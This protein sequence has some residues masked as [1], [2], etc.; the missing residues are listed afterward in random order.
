MKS[1]KGTNGADARALIGRR[2]GS[3]TTVPQALA[4]NAAA[5]P[6]RKAAHDAHQKQHV[7]YQRSG[8]GPTRR[9]YGK[10]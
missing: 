2:G 7:N 4:R 5:A 1:V 9:F 8:S 3:A 10:G 6:A